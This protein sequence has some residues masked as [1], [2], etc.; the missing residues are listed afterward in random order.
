MI[1]VEADLAIA[2]MKTGMRV[3][4]SPAKGGVRLEGVTV[5]CD[6]ATGRATAVAPVRVEVG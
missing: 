4:F 2:R 6:P 3:R 1:G 5:D